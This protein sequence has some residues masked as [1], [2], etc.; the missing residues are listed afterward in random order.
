MRSSEQLIAGATVHSTPVNRGFIQDTFTTLKL[1]KTLQ[2]DAFMAIE[3]DSKWGLYN[4]L[5]DV[6]T[7][8]ET[9]HADNL[10]RKVTRHLLAA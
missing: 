3:D 10:N 8:Q 2:A 4:G 6:L 9:H 7:R 1:P 5:T